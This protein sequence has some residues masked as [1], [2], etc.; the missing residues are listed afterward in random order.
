LILSLSCL[1]KGKNNNN[2]QKGFKHLVTKDC[3]ILLFFF[4]A[5]H[6]LVHFMLTAL[7]VDFN[8][9]KQMVNEYKKKHNIIWG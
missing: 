5:A 7:E 9:R 2:K 1:E 4:H 8:Q 6:P 3:H